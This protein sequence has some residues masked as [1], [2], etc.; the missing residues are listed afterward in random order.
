MLEWSGE[1][2]KLYFDS[3]FTFQFSSVGLSNLHRGFFGG[4]F[5]LRSFFTQKR[6]TVC[7]SVISLQARNYYQCLGTQWP[8]GDLVVTEFDG[9]LEMCLSASILLET[10]ICDP[11][12]QRL[13]RQERWWAERLPSKYQREHGRSILFPSQV[14]SGHVEKQ[15]QGRTRPFKYHC[16]RNWALVD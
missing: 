6:K 13:H 7:W 16:P 5:H 11:R 2:R 15:V 4:L 12:Q 3:E 10:V 9:Q 14:V 1:E 8:C